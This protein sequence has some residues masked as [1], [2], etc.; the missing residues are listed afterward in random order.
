MRLSILEH[1]RFFFQKQAGFSLI[2]VLAATAILGV[3]TALALPD[4]GKL[5][6]TYQL[7]CAAEEMAMHIRI[8]Q[9]NAMRYESPVYRVLFYE[10]GDSYSIISDHRTMKYTTVK[11]QPSV[12]L[13]YHNFNRPGY[14]GL[15]F[16]ANGNPIYRFG[17]HIAL[18]SRTTGAYRYIIINS[19]GRV[20][21]DDKPPE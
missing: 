16:A 13:A 1:K 6:G 10:M 12:R 9:E 7:N 17:G 19:I 18:Q 20:R 15:I 4:F 11:L 2:E 21:I 8:Q 14:N 5:F 3:I